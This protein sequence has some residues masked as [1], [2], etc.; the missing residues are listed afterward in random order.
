MTIIG[1]M[2]LV[3]TQLHTVLNGYW[4]GRNK[5]TET[6]FEDFDQ[7]IGSH[8]DLTNRFPQNIVNIMEQCKR[9][10]TRG[11][12]AARD[13]NFELAQ[14]SF[15]AASKIIALT[16]MSKKYSL[17][18]CAFQQAAEA[19]L[20][21][22][23]GD[24][25]KARKRINDALVMDRLLIDEHNYE[26]LQIPHMRRLHN[27]MRIEVRVGKWEEAMNLGSHILNDLTNPFGWSLKLRDILPP[28]LLDNV[29]IFYANQFVVEMAQILAAKEGEE[30]YDLFSYIRP[31][32]EE[33]AVVDNH[34]LLDYQYTW[35]HM[36][37]LL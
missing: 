16:P 30:L 31:F 32:S 29:I 33:A 24:F 23:L 12:Q 1:S 26:V 6:L 27:L 2:N 9:Y 8:I 25:D 11:L 14:Q 22:R 10:R 5:P 34:H 28:K 17:Y 36:K 20:D 7:E 4:H 15:M 18:L 21:Y 35:L 13:D 19:Y 3:D 37:K